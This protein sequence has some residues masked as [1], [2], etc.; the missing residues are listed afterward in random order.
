M[1]MVQFVDEWYGDGTKL[2]I[3]DFV[4]GGTLKTTGEADLARKKLG[5]GGYC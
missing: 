5:R 2:M 1:Q 3:L 4:P